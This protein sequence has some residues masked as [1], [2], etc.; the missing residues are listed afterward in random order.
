V[1]GVEE[2]GG[3]RLPP[4]KDRPEHRL[5]IGEREARQAILNGPMFAI[6]ARQEASEPC[7]PLLIAARQQQ[8]DRTTRDAPCQE[9]QEFEA[10]IVAPVQILDDDQERSQRRKAEEDIREQLED[11]SLLALGVRTGVRRRRDG[12]RVGD[13]GGQFR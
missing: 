8:Q 3:H 5:D 4:G 11:A 2:I 9:E 13:Q 6:N 10:G 12:L 1:Q 7:V